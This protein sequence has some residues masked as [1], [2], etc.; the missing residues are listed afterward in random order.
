[1]GPDQ[2]LRLPLLAQLV[3]LLQKCSTQ[4]ALASLVF[5][6]SCSC[7]SVSSKH[8]TTCMHALC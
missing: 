6:P 4:S 1:M 7:S 5:T 2:G 8:L 3:D